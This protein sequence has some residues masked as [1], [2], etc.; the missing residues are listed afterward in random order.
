MGKKNQDDASSLKGVQNRD[1]LQRL[2]FLYQASV[3]LNNISAAGPSS[4]QAP[5]ET[6]TTHD[7][8]EGHVPPVQ[9]QDVPSSSPKPR[10]A[11]RR[12]RKDSKRK[13]MSTSELS[14]S[15]VDA[16]KVI[17]QKTI[18]KMDP[19]VKRTLCK[20]CNTVLVPGVTA[21]V[22][23]KG[24]PVHG[25]VVSY[26]CNACK[27]V[28]RIPAPPIARPDELKEAS[29]VH[30][31]APSASLEQ[32]ASSDPIDPA[33]A[34]PQRQQPKNRRKPKASPRPLPHF[35][36]PEHIVFCGNEKITIEDG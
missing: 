27:T 5:D 10:P 32:A 17:G 13:V 12:Q 3:F 16:M 23:V 20:G 8:A 7:G 36:R 21:R 19:S 18:V 35:A 14:R 28:R 31:G 30:A 22:R 1:I 6:D 4:P 2:N 33:T 29:Q 24:S 9:D 26:T 15:Y 11:R 34:S 25:N